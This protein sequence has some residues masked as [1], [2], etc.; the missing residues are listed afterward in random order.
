ML[1]VV[2]WATGAVGRHAVRAVQAHPDL[3]LVGAFVYSDAK[4]GRDVGEIAGLAPIG[5]TATNDPAEIVVLD[6]DCVLY[7]AQGEMNPAGALDDICRLLA[8]GK[9][10]I[11]TAVT[12][13][14]YPASLDPAVAARLEEACAEG[15]TSFHATGIEPGWASEV[16]PLTMS[17]LFERID[18]LVVQELLDYSSYDSPGMMFD[19][20]GFGRAPDAPV[21]LADPVLAGSVFRAPLLLVAEG[22]GATIDDFVYDRQVALA[23]RAFDIKAGRVEAGTVSAQ[24]FS[25]TAVVG[26]RPALTVE[27]ITRVGEGQAP[28]W[29]TGRGWKVTVEGSPSMVL[30]A[31]IAIHGEDENDQGCLG[32]AMHAVHAIAP[33][34]AAAPGIR[35]FLDLP[36]IKGRHILSQR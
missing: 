12:S 11:S 36:M 32:T 31:K 19:I 34:C 10:V 7:M 9:N 20:M 18:T 21:P 8:A 2:Q 30:E 33:V 28:D 16:L 1:R 23:D 29:P 24:R 27:H 6:A 14:I 17:A 3:E 35:T 4:A 25:A 22:L 26:G 5:V 15:G 13:L